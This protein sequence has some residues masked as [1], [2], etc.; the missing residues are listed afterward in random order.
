MRFW[1]SLRSPLLRPTISRLTW[2][3][4]FVVLQ[5]FPNLLKILS[6]E[7]LITRRWCQPLRFWC[8]QGIDGTCG[9]SKLPLPGYLFG[10]NIIIPLLILKVNRE[11]NRNLSFDGLPV[12]H[13]TKKAVHFRLNEPFLVFL[14][15]LLPQLQFSQDII[16]AQNRT[17]S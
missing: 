3:I 13:V 11:T 9:L 7:K 2:Q 1:R 10:S 17:L 15:F 16:L 5:P 14:S 6:E 12:F 4:G 8:G